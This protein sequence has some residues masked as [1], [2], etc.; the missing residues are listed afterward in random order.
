MKGTL[1]I[2]NGITFITLCVG[3]SIIYLVLLFHRNSL[4]F[5][6]LAAVGI[7]SFIY[8]LRIYDSILFDLGR[9]EYIGT[10]THWMALIYILFFFTFRGQK[11]LNLSLL[12]YVLTLLPGIYHVFFSM[13]LSV[14]TLDTLIQYY[15][16]NLVYIFSL[17]Y[18]Q[19]IIEFYLQAET[20]HHIANTDYLTALPNRRRMDEL[21]QE[22]IA[23]STLSA[24]PLS[25][26]LFDVD[27]F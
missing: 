19:K 14:D 2:L 22:G 15:I 26:A 21:L 13:Q 11:A 7:S 1:D 4:R 16:S 23:A 24:T 18:L 9:Y 25:V 27:F 10:V 17:F 8:L 5:T 20:A 3:L 6:E 12:L